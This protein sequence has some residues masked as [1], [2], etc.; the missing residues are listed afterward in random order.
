MTSWVIAKPTTSHYTSQLHGFT[1][2]DGIPKSFT[3]KGNAAYKL[4]QAQWDL[5][6]VFSQFDADGDG[7]LTIAELKRAFV[8][9]ASRPAPHHSA[10][11][12][13][14]CRRRPAAEFARG[15]QHA[16]IGCALATH[17]GVCPSRPR[18]V[19]IPAP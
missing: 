8:S 9:A 14:A 12:E 10:R 17:A 19:P 7:Y 5:R 13:P 18:R 4:S 6:G 2:S 1:T 3:S 11:C 16:S 15:R